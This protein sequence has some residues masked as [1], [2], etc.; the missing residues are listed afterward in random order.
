V[1]DIKDSE[2]PTSRTTR[3]SLGALS[4]AFIL[5]VIFWAGAAYNRID[6]I[7]KSLGSINAK[8]ER[9]ADINLIQERSLR[10]EKRIERLEQRLED[11]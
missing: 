3:I 1:T 10:N 7:E 6:G 8:L 5:G 9:L 4:G 2:S 11:R